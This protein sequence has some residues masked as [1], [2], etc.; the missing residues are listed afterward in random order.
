MA[1][2]V[3]FMPKDVHG[4][5]HIIKCFCEYTKRFLEMGETLGQNR[6][7]RLNGFLNTLL[8]KMD[9]LSSKHPITHKLIG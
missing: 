1:T 2:L 7:K 3:V 5:I 4:C 8:T 9:A 6:Q